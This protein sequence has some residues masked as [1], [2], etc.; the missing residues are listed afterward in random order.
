M[1]SARRLTQFGLGGDACDTPASRLDCGT[2]RTR[3]KCRALKH[4]NSPQL[5][6]RIGKRCE[7][8]CSLYFQRHSRPPRSKAC[9]FATR[10]QATTELGAP[11]AAEEVCARP[12]NRTEIRLDIRSEERR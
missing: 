12:C 3:D 1:N 5:L 2:R 7:Q 4:S 9:A 6:C 10:R 8:P 11:R